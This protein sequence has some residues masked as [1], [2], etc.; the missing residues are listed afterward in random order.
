MDQTRPDDRHVFEVFAPEKAVV[1]VAVAE[2]L[3]RVRRV[4]FG[5][6][7]L[8]RV[9]QR[10]RRQDRRARLELDRDA[11]L[12]VDGK[13]AVRPGGHPHGSTARAGRRAIA[14]LIAG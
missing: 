4:G 3:V 1:P 9:H 8:A 11:A 6:I 5:G 10:V 14:W 13:T 7:V 12:Q 2:I